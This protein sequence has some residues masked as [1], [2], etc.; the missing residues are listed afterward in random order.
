MWGAF[1]WGLMEKCFLS[2]GVECRMPAILSVLERAIQGGVDIINIQEAQLFLK[3]EE[4]LVDSLTPLLDFFKSQDYNIFYKG[5][6]PSVESFMY[7][8]AFK[9]GIQLQ[10]CD[11]FED[12][13]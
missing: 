1:T 9:K 13:A 6:N 11:L 5:S 12:E 10:S 8:T 3:D 4:V 2:G 7:I